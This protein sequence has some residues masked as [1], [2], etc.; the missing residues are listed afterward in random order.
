MSSASKEL[1]KLRKEAE[2]QGWKVMETS[3]GLQFFAPDGVNI[4]T[5]H[6][7]ASDHRAFRNNVGRLKR[8]GFQWKG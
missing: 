3:D 4:V 8:F 7:T 1:K 6:L 5:M 2:K